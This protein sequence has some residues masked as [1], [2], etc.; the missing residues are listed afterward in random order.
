[1]DMTEEKVWY[2]EWFDSEYYHLLYQ[3]RDYTEAAKFLD[4]LL[5]ALDVQPRE[6][7]LDLAC[8]RG[9]HSIYL[10]TK[11]LLV[12]GIDLSA[13]NIS[14][15]SEEENERLHFA[16][17]DMR[18]SYKERYFDYVFNLFT[19]FGYF[20]SDAEN[21]MVLKAA[22]REPEDKRCFRAGL[23]ECLQGAG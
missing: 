18:E 16:V 11:D 23:H 15:A 7:V 17:H 10:S 14:Q 6:K 4:K 2:S 13:K 19:S 22:P 20:E 8:G 12:T 9:R 1:M 3:E 5:S 21:V